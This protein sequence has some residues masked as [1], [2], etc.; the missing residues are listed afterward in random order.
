MRREYTFVQQ[1]A[2]NR[3]CFSLLLESMG[4][5]MGAATGGIS[6]VHAILLAGGE[7]VCWPKDTLV[8]GVAITLVVC[9]VGRWVEETGPPPCQGAHPTTRGGLGLA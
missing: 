1:T 9:V 3:R 4:A 7:G 2:H 6:H 8:N 5:R